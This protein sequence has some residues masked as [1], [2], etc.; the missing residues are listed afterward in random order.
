MMAFIN[1]TRSSPPASLHHIST[2]KVLTHFYL[3]NNEKLAT[4]VVHFLT[5]PEENN[6]PFVDMEFT[7][8]VLK[9]HTNNA[10]NLSTNNN[11][12]QQQQQQ[13]QQTVALVA[14]VALVRKNSR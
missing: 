4:A 6:L 9:I 1:K 8:Q 14:L 10:N 12:K 13:Q 2:L 11:N 7:S 5:H 3:L